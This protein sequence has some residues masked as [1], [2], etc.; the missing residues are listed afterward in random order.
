MREAG[1]GGLRGSVRRMRIVDLVR[2]DEMEASLREHLARGELPDVFLY[3]GEDGAGNWLD[4]DTSEA[5]DVAS[6]LTALIRD[7][8]EAVAA[9]VPAGATVVSLG[10]GGGQ[11]ER[12][13]LAALAGSG[14][15]TYIAA[16][17]SR[18]L[19]EEALRA[20]DDLDV[21]VLGATARIEDLSRLCR[22]VR[23]PV[24][25]CL[26]G[27]TFSNFEPDTL[28][29]RVGDHLEP[30]DLFLFDCH[31]GPSDEAESAAWREG[32]E[33]AYGSA[34]NARFNLG[35]LTAR[36]ADPAAC[37]F[38]LRLTQT[39]TR[40]GRTWRTVKIVH[41]LRDAEVAFPSGPLRLRGG[42]QIRMGFTY[43]HTRRQVLGWVRKAGYETVEAFAD[44]D[45][46]H[47]LVL[48][49]KRI[50]DSDDTH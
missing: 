3:L 27:N 30:G 25:L 46:A 40:M 43:K 11:K 13:L 17:V 38:S 26:L 48:V 1:R 24:L 41:L 5:F 44:A 47:L 31:L 39:R 23:R 34:E 16:D 18:T 9:H 6:D 8:A 32:I 50:G 45:D 19:V 28:L 10:V 29:E 36:G 20:V 15:R 35:P 12:I 49:R 37:R 33:Q 14:A 22:H 4:L 21:D 7:R 2:P 42:E